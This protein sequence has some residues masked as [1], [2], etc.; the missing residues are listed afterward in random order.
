[1][2][3]TS[4]EERMN[5]CVDGPLIAELIYTH[6]R[7]DTKVTTIRDYIS[8]SQPILNYI[9]GETANTMP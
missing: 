6:N 2:A 3:V 9:F 5:C 8:S 7:K 1:V 4:E